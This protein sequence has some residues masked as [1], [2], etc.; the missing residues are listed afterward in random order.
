MKKMSLPWILLPS[1]KKRIYY[2]ICMIKFLLN[3]I[4]PSNDMLDKMNKLFGS[5]P[6]IDK[7]ALGFP[8]GWE[9]EP[10]WNS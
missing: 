1:D 10:L 5:F 3:I 4:S 9:N 8:I 7:K 6:E 2:N